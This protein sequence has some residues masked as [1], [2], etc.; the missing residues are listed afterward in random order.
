[1]LLYLTGKWSNLGLMA[2]EAKSVYF[3]LS[4]ENRLHLT[5]SES[6]TDSVIQDQCPLGASPV[7]CDLTVM[8]FCC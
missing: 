3:Q 4:S 7:V 5:E 2:V 8:S 1:M 6:K